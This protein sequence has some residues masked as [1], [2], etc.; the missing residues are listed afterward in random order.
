MGGAASTPGASEKDVQK[1]CRT[2]GLS[3]DEVKL[4]SKR[5]MAMAGT[6]GKLSAADLPTFS[7]PKIRAFAEKMLRTLEADG[8]GYVTFASFCDGAAKFLPSLPIEV[9]LRSKGVFC[10]FVASLPCHPFHLTFF[11]P[12][13]IQ[14]CFMFWMR[15]KMK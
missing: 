2:T 13:H 4:L 11:F 7:S 8:R 9:R 1:I 6:S 3:R 12:Q 10:L 5:Y 15:I 14:I